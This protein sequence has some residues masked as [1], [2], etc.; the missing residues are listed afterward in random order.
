MRWCFTDSDP[1]T[2]RPHVLCRLCP[3]GLSSCHCRLCIA[4][5]GHW[6]EVCP[7]HCLLMPRSAVIDSYFVASVVLLYQAVTTVFP[8]VVWE[9]LCWQCKCPSGSPQIALCAQS[10]CFCFTHMPALPSPPCPTT[11]SH[12]LRHF[13]QLY[14]RITATI[15]LTFEEPALSGANLSH[16]ILENTV[17]SPLRPLV[18]PPAPSPFIMFTPPSILLPPWCSTLLSPPSLLPIYSLMSGS[19]SQKSTSESTNASY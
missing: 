13:L 16:P 19:K 7:E 5:L 6:S 1:S 4:R 9:I 3:C 8:I 18:S 11:F 10:C 15:F 14:T 12:R 2:C 17:V